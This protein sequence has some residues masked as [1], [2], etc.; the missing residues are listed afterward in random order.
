MTSISIFDAKTNLSR[1][2]RLAQQGEELII[3]T[4]RERKPV[5]KLIAVETDL[6]PEKRRIGFLEGQG[7]IGP[8]VLRSAARG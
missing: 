3:T 4:G 1:L 7:S 6:H 2:I 8:G 5:A